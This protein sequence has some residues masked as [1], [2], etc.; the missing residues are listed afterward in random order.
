MHGDQ[1]FDTG[2]RSPTLES[3]I[4]LSTR[5]STRSVLEM[6]LEGSRYAPKK[7]R[8]HPSDIEP[9]L[10]KFER[11][12]A[13]KNQEKCETVLDY[14]GRTVRETIEGFASYQNYDWDQLKRDIKIYW[15]ADLESKRFRIADLEKFVTKSVRDPI[16]E[17]KDWRGYLRDF[18]RIGGWLK[19]HG[20]ISEDN[21]AYYLWIGLHPNAM[22]KAAKAL[23]SVDRFDTE[24]LRA[25]GRYETDSEDD[26]ESDSIQEVTGLSRRRS[27]VARAAHARTR[28]RK[29][30]DE[31]ES[32]GDELEEF[33]K[34]KR[35]EFN[36]QQQEKKTE[37]AKKPKAQSPS[38]SGLNEILE[39]MAHLSLNDKNYGILYYQARQIDPSITTYIQPPINRPPVASQPRV[40]YEQHIPRG[41]PPHM[42]RP[43]P[44]RLLQ[45]RGP[46]PPMPMNAGC[47]G[48]GKAGHIM[49]YCPKINEYVQKGQVL[50]DHLGR[51]VDKGGNVIRRQ[52][53]ENLVH[54]IEQMFPTVSYVA[55]S[56]HIE[57]VPEEEESYVSYQ[58]E[59]DL[60]AY[61][62]ERAPRETRS[63]LTLK[64][65]EV[66][67]SLK[68]VS[69]NLGDLL[70][71]KKAE[72]AA[73]SARRVPLIQ[74]EMECDFKPV[75][76]IVDT[77]SQL[78]IISQ[79]I[80]QDVVRRPINQG[81]IAFMHDA[82]GGRT[83][84]LGIVEDIPLKIGHIKTPITAYIQEKAP[85]DGLL[86][87]LWQQ[88]HKISI[89]ERE[90]G[91]YL[92]FP[93]TERYPKSEMLVAWPSDYDSDGKAYSVIVKEWT[94]EEALRIR[95]AAATRI[96][97]EEDEDP[98]QDM[99]ELETPDNELDTEAESDSHPEDSG[100]QQGTNADSDSSSIDEDCEDKAEDPPQDDSTDESINDDD[101]L[102]NT[103]DKLDQPVNPVSTRLRDLMVYFPHKTDRMIEAE[104]AEKA[105]AERL[106][107]QQS[108]DS[109]ILS[110]HEMDSQPQGIGPRYNREDFEESMNKMAF[111]HE[112]TQ[113]QRQAT[114]EHEPSQAQIE[115]DA[116]GDSEM[117][118]MEDEESDTRERER[119]TEVGGNDDDDISSTPHQSPQNTQHVP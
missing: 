34:K 6:P 96:T 103:T 8:G 74:L 44:N 20:K 26:E 32:S 75:T 19:G 89:E 22:D 64:L 70:K 107:A 93:P 37:A 65:R 114:L 83:A 66:L 115:S 28:R 33:R 42:D 67:G 91:T 36:R 101:G 56:T 100:E 21:F 38:D 110:E 2:Y 97:P 18:I 92:M 30:D 84:L 61:P 116:D 99:P 5:S 82:S 77:G 47:Y 119:D 88:A 94:M 78:N 73:A 111:E 49:N 40:N 62:V 90:D 60:A 17:L 46:P 108:T 52:E 86:G 9:F 58:A 118:D 3:D 95:L 14:C 87:R 31:D 69:S 98:F 104:M 10:R 59:A 41:V 85:F 1:Q 76:F 39:K 72:P 24:R 112:R 43:N 48:C 29:T 7:F 79:Q 54:T 23:L 113:Q 4:T 13:L 63:Y 15:N 105:Q 50:K 102:P 16:T 25:K 71:P 55:F 80:C 35:E 27:P 81:E 117:T 45:R 11:L 12:A 53:G 57:E 106:E 51:V 68:E 109:L